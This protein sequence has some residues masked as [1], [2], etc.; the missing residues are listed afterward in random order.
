MTKATYDTVFPNSM[1]LSLKNN[2]AMIGLQTSIAQEWAE[3][4]LYPV[5]YESLQAHLDTE[6]AS[7][8]F[9]TI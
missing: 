4:R 6:P 9:I 5:V 2:T 8:V 7:L 1:L 3:N